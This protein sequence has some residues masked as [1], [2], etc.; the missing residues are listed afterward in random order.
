VLLLAA[1]LWLLL[2][3]IS[4]RPDIGGITL[5][6]FTVALL[7]GGA[8]H[9]SLETIRALRRRTRLTIAGFLSDGRPRARDEIVEGILRRIPRLRFPPLRWLHL[10]RQDLDEM[11]RESVLTLSDGVYSAARLD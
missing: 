4:E 5:V 8:W 6:A 1:A 11:T 3:L 9:Q 7:A 10:H 2:F